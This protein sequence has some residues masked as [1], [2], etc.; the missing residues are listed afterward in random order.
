M[1]FKIIT[2]L[3]L[4]AAQLTM[5]CGVQSNNDNS[6]NIVPKPTEITLGNSIFTLDSSTELIST[7]KNLEL[8]YVADEVNKITELIVGYK[9]K[10]NSA[11]KP[12][13]NAINFIYDGSLA[14]EEYKMEVTKS[15][16]NITS[17]TA[18]GAFYAVKSLEQ[19]IAPEKLTKD[20]TST[21]EFPTCKIIDKPHF[22]Y[23][24]MML[25]VCRHFFTVEEVKKNIDMLA[26]HKINTL[27]WHLTEDQGW[28]IEIKKYP[29]LTEIGSIREETKIGGHHD[30]TKGYDGVKYGGYYTQEQIKEV[31]EYAKSKFITIIPEIELPGHAVAALTSYPHLGC[32]GEGYKVRTTWGV[33]ENVFCAG[34]ESTYEFFEDVLTE[35]IALFPS[36]Y[37]HIGGD[38]CPKNMWRK[39]THCQA[40]IKTEKLNNEDELQ[41]Y[42][43]RR[44]EKFLQQHNRQ[45]IGW[46]EI[47]EGG[48]SSTATVMSWRG[49]EGGITAAKQGNNV[50]MSPSTYCYL[51]YYQAEDIENEPLAM[52]RPLP[53]SKVY[54][55]DPYQGLNSVEQQYIVG[56]QGNVWT[57]YIKTISHVEYMA[58]PRIGAI[59]EIGWS[60]EANKNYSNF[61]HRANNLAKLYDLYGFNYAKH[62]LK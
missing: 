35:V 11:P 24:G 29:R 40:R 27:H 2:S 44:V 7:Y 46:D 34:Q 59:A 26:I 37:I 31:V 4:I 45:I 54:S 39:C 22:A 50:I 12:Q 20:C 60:Y 5:C 6:L 14:S 18:N 52:G 16:I 10:H 55:F 57:E 42:V 8:V 25:D 17:A 58:L 53:L 19:M 49:V 32:K 43:T 30:T 48:V 13:E 28:R 47:L 51:D 38:E 33:D 36:T 15:Q 62:T 9:L 23:R 41:G 3:L 56:V 21:L 61:L 1:K